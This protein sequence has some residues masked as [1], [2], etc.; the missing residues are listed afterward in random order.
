MGRYAWIEIID[1][2]KSVGLGGLLRRRKKRFQEWTGSGHGKYSSPG[3]NLKGQLAMRA[4]AIGENATNLGV[5]SSDVQNVPMIPRIPYKK[6]KGTFVDTESINVMEWLQ[7]DCAGR[8][9]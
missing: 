2:G 6:P 9:C 8:Y 4:P 5:D 3:P 1:Q 7:R